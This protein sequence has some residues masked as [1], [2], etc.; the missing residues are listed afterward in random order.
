MSK[1]AL[2]PTSEAARI[3][4]CDVRTVHRAVQ[5]GDLTP[6]YT[7]PRYRGDMLFDP[8]EVDRFRDVWRSRRLGEAS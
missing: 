8:A 5:R 1:A 7:M 3:V 4:G 6:A 2:L